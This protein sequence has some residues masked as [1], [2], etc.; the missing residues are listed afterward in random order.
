[1]LDRRALAEYKRRIDELH[2]DLA[3]AEA[4]HDGGRIAKLASERDF[5]L[6]ELSAA[7][8]LGGRHRRLGDDVDRQRKAVRARLRDAIGRIEAVH[9]ELGRHLARAVRTGAFCAYDPEVPVDWTV[10]P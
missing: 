4:N 2:A 9:P 8:G 5:L 10:R 6:D 7:A 1:M 3:E